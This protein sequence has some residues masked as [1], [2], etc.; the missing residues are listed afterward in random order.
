MAAVTKI[1]DLRGFE[2]RI[3]LRAGLPEMVVADKDAACRSRCS[4]GVRQCLTPKAPNSHVPL[5]GQGSLTELVFKA[6]PAENTP[7]I[8]R[9]SDVGQGG[10]LNSLVRLV[11]PQRNRY[12]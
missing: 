12:L 1:T 4:H 6:I 11:R 3:V 7:L 8:Q 10:Q 5:T 9:P 2:D